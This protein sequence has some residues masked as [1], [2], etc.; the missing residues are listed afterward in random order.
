MRHIT[1]RQ[2]NYLIFMAINKTAVT[3]RNKEARRTGHH[4]LVLPGMYMLEII[5]CVFLLITI[6]TNLK[7]FFPS[8]RVLPSTGRKSKVFRAKVTPEVKPVA[9]PCKYRV[10]AELGAEVSEGARGEGGIEREAGSVGVG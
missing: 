9:V 3:F 7:Y 8:L 10:E 1:G 2:T 6:A 4:I 5:T